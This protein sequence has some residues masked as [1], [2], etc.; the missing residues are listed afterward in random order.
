MGRPRQ[1]RCFF[2]SCL[3]RCL[4]C[5]KRDGASPA[6]R[7]GSSRASGKSAPRLR[8]LSSHREV[9]AGTALRLARSRAM[10]GAPPGCCRFGGTHPSGPAAA[11]VLAQEAFEGSVKD[12]FVVVETCGEVFKR[13][14]WKGL[15]W[16]R[17]CE[18]PSS[19]MPH[20]SAHCGSGSIRAPTEFQLRQRL[21]VLAMDRVNEAP[22]G[23]LVLLSRHTVESLS[24]KG[25]EARTVPRPPIA[26][27]KWTSRGVRRTR[28]SGQPPRK[29]RGRRRRA[30][31]RDSGGSRSRCRKGY[32]R[33][34][35]QSWPP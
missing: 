33:S 4:A 30:G 9:F 15:L 5:R 3:T 13:F 2:R 31:Q 32:S 23:L 14:Q 27:S 26:C 10:P 29:E 20:A 1:P 22:D 34:P 19:K 24:A 8:W 11:P 17:T 7:G 35:G 16:F 18:I 25:P 28:T 6:A 21:K 12:L